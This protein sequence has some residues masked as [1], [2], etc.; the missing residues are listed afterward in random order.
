MAVIGWVPGRFGQ[1]ISAPCY[2]L[3]RTS[4]HPQC[5]QSRV[6]VPARFKHFC[7]QSVSLVA[8]PLMGD[9]AG[10]AGPYGPP[11]PGAMGANGAPGAGPNPDWG[12][13]G[14]REGPRRALRAPS[15]GDA[16]CTFLLVV[17]AL[18]ACVGAWKAPR[19]APEVPPPLAGRGMRGGG[20]PEF[21]LI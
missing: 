18:H 20:R 12:G 9:G 7:I 16:F 13:V 2:T 15:R 21:I 4:G 10:G 19:S 6:S 17:A 14:A 3:L 11:Q 8:S 5:T 1:A